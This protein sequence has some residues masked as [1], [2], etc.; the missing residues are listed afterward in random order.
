MFPIRKLLWPALV[1]AVLLAGCQ[2]QT[3][4]PRGPQAVFSL[5]LPNSLTQN[6]QSQQAL[7]LRA[8]A[9]PC[10][11]NG[12][13]QPEPFKNGYSM[14]R[15]TTAIM[16]TWT[17]LA[18]TVIHVVNFLPHDGQIY[19]ATDNIKGSDGYRSQDPTHYSVTDDGESQ[20]SVRLYYGYD[21]NSPPTDTDKPGFYISWHDDGSG[22]KS[23]RLVI[24]TGLIDDPSRKPDDPSRMRMDFNY[25]GVEKRMHMYLQFD[26]NDWANGFHLEVSQDLTANRL[27]Q[28]FTARALM[29]MKR[30]FADN[31]TS[32]AL[33]EFK[34][35]TVANQLGDGA[36]LA[37]FNSVAL[38][39]PLSETAHLG[40]Y[41]FDKTDSYYFQENHDW[42]WI[43]KTFSNVS[44]LNSRNLPAEGGSWPDDPSLAV[45]R[46]AYG[47]PLDYFSNGLCELPAD[48]CTLLFNTIFE[49]GFPGQEKNTGADPGD[50][51]SEALDGVV[52]LD[53]VYPPGFTTWEGVFEMGFTP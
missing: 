41:L 47:L 38:S 10:A 22:G 1:S 32:T 30:Q 23:G 6:P 15:F 12:A 5:P 29:D 21:E 4:P 19:A 49:D 39:L 53:S 31:V 11:F 14:T 18:D 7:H 33:P 48:D 45:I 40:E 3:E 20:T 51:R 16:A 17:C 28:V 2:N 34:M 9:L 24:E 26:N 37:Q 25:T 36:A 8:A 52:Y 46:D 42:D 27:Q 35:Y 50:W 43:H 13:D 44:Y